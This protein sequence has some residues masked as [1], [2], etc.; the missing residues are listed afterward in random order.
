MPRKRTWYPTKKLI[1]KIHKDMLEEFGG[2]PEFDRGINVFDAILEEVKKT[3]GV[4]RKAAVLLRRMATGRIFDDGNHRTAFEVTF[5]F[6][7]LNDAE[8]KVKDTKKII[9]FI[10]DIW[11]YNIDEIE[12]WLR[13]GQV[14]K[15]S[16]S[17]SEGKHE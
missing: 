1:I 3:R 2:R 4:Y 6:L 11:F 12:A 10:K 9:R 5:M 7:Q 15:E 16:Y 17:C 13:N 8:M 14:P